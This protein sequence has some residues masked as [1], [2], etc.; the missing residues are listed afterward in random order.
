[1][2][3]EKR[4]FYHGTLGLVPI[5]TPAP[6]K[7]STLLA[8]LCVVIGMET[9]LVWGQFQNLYTVPKVCAVLI[10]AACILPLLLLH[11]LRAQDYPPSFQSLLLIFGLQVIA[12]AL[13]TMLSSSPSVSFWGGDWR[14]MGLITSTAMLVIAIAVPLA[15]DAGEKR[16]GQFLRFLVATGLLAGAYGILQWLGFDPFVSPTMRARIIQQSLGVF[17]SPG[18]IGQ[19]THYANYLIYPFF[20]A[21][22]LLKLDPDAKWKAC[23]RISMIAIVTG[24]FSSLSRGGIF[25]IGCGLLFFLFAMLIFRRREGR[26]QPRQD[27]PISRN[28]W[29][30]SGLALLLIGAIALLGVRF[31]LETREGIPYRERLSYF[32]RD[33]TASERTTAWRDIVLHV[34]PRVWVQGTGIG[35]FRPAF[36]QYRSGSYLQNL[37]THWETPHNVFLDRLCE[38]GIFGLSVFLVLL[39]AALLSLLRSYRAALDHRN[40]WALLSLASG[41]VGA[42]ASNLFNGEAIP[43]TFYFYLWI[44]L[45]FAAGDCFSPGDSRLLLGKSPF[46]SRL[47]RRVLSGA[48]CALAAFFAWHAYRNWRAEAYL[49]KALAAAASNDYDTLIQCGLSSTRAFPETGAYHF[50]FCEAIFSCFTEQSTK[51]MDDSIRWRLLRIGIEQGI[52][53]KEVSDRSMVA[54]YYLSAMGLYADDPRTGKWIRSL[55]QQ[56]PHWY[57]GHT[58]M[59]SFLARLGRFDEARTYADEADR[60]APSRAPELKAWREAVG[61][62]QPRGEPLQKKNP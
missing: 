31:F 37:D 36:A 52:R 35:M 18:P 60:L 54:L 62:H 15:L 29:L 22:A 53:A 11:L 10:G 26:V 58:L 20:A 5:R 16:F 30:R 4:V 8:V 38:Q 45:S 46:G 47:N 9:L 13:A 43:T 7:S 14:R 33:R 61:L 21:V 1:M 25:G 34:V 50:A 49:A 42:L 41:L 39:T 23:A 27:V 3:A 40:R 51:A 32:I 19:P 12:L 55:I 48:V 6:A 59:A 28:R 44:A 24:S 2:L 17:R 57:R 56:D